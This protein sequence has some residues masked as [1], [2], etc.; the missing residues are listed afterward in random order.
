MDT[1]GRRGLVY[2]PIPDPIA[3]GW[4]KE[5]LEPRL[6]RGST[7]RITSTGACR[8]F[9]V[10]NPAAFDGEIELNPSVLLGSGTTGV[11]VVINDGDREVRA[12]VFGNGGAG[13]RVAL[14]R[15]GGC[16]PGFV[17]RDTLVSFRLKRLADGTGFLAVNGRT[18]ETV[19]RS[20][21][22]LSRRL[23]LHTLEFG[24]DATAEV[25][26]AEWFTL[27]LPA[28]ARR[29]PAAAVIVR[30]LRLRERL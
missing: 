14:E 13:V 1:Y 3:A 7:L 19:A 2:D 24:S 6:T 12:A 30:R 11:F 23:G 17:L 21:Q 26:T 27:G 25:T 29:T 20:A 4:T 28:M 10:T 18:P 8:F 9:V 16:T 22:V 5:G 15:E